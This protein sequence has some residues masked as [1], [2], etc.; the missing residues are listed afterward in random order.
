MIKVFRIYAEK[1]SRPYFL[2]LTRYDKNKIISFCKEKGLTGKIM[3]EYPIK[4]GAHQVY[5]TKF[6]KID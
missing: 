6:I 3:V 5:K 4:N 1:E 2:R